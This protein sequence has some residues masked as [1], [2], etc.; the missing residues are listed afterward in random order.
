[1]PVGTEICVKDVLQGRSNVSM[2]TQTSNTVCFRTAA[3]L[4]ATTTTTVAP[5]TTTTPAVTDNTT[6]AS[7]D[8]EPSGAG[9][10]GDVILSQP[11]TEPAPLAELPRTGSSS[12]T[13]VLAG[14]LAMLV[15]GFLVA[16]GRR[17]SAGSEA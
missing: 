15:G 5:T 2:P 4:P 11:A 14:T 10:G 17:R 3:A 16:L 6:G 1:M 7:P 13:L 12:A 8:V 9:T